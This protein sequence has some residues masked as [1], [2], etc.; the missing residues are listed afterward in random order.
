[1]LGKIKTYVHFLEEEYHRKLGIV[2][3]RIA[4]LIVSETALFF[5]TGFVCDTTDFKL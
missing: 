1:M 2:G 3:V 5:C 4:G